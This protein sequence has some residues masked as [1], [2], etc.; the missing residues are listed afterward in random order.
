[1]AKHTPDH[2]NYYSSG[3]EF[4]S[5]LMAEN[6]DPAETFA[7]ESFA[8]P[9]SGFFKPKRWETAFLWPESY[10]GRWDCLMFEF[11][12]KL[13]PGILTKRPRTHGAGSVAGRWIRT[14][15]TDRA[16][17]CPTSMTCRLCPRRYH[18]HRND[19]SL[20]QKNG[21]QRGWSIE[22][23]ERFELG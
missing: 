11:R 19:S 20:K 10:F 3:F 6:C 18:H 17:A 2:W 16:T 8:G 23:S 12:L 22:K 13:A 4:E 14:K 1:M 15:S 5:A 21:R 9:I 7:C